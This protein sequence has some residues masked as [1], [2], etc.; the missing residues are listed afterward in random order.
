MWQV[1]QEQNVDQYEKVAEFIT[2]VTEMVPG[3]MNYRLKSQLILGLRARVS[4]CGYKDYLSFP[5][6]LSVEKKQSQWIQGPEVITP[7]NANYYML[8]VGL[9]S[10]MR[11]YIK[12]YK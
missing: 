1:A 12:L 11:Q 5:D 10:P 9:L 2:L 4:E 7:E 3:L 6:I 8:A